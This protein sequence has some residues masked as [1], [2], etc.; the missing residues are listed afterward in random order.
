[1]RPSVVLAAT[2]GPLS[3]C[4]RAMPFGNVWLIVRSRG[5]DALDVGELRLP[6]YAA[7]PANIGLFCSQ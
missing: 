7:V 2:T 5:S 4:A 3:H 6:M 1:M